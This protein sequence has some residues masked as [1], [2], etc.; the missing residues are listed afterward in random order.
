MTV[1][2]DDEIA[3]LQ[4]EHAAAHRSTCR[5]YAT[6]GT[7]DAYNADAA[8]WP[9]V[10]ATVACTVLDPAGAAGGQ[11]GIV[12]VLP[13]AKAKTIVLPRGTTVAPSWRIV[14]TDEAITYS[15]VDVERNGSFGPAVYCQC[16]E[17]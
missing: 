14:W 11:G 6:V 8:S 12:D 2:T 16:V 3:D 13:D 10:T 9:T 1:L 17:V 7:A 5:L 15:V 4:G